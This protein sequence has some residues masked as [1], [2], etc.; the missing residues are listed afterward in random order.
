MIKDK[1]LDNRLVQSK[2]W[3]LYGIPDILND[4]KLTFW[5]KAQQNIAI[6]CMS[7]TQKWLVRGK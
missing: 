1:N 7:L 6:F 2:Y 3:T 4:D 5:V